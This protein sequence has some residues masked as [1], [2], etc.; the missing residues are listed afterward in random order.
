M[1]T[2]QEV[3]KEI[4]A[5]RA[6]TLI[7]AGGR[8]NVRREALPELKEEYRRYRYIYIR[9]QS[10]PVIIAFTFDEWVD[11]TIGRFPDGY[12]A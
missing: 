5:F 7:N 10:Y 12:V 4:E 2:I 9:F 1:R 11:M 6:R 3:E 8:E